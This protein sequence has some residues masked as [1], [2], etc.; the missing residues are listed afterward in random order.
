MYTIDHL[1]AVSVVSAGIVFA[2]WAASS[3]LC[4]VDGCIGCMRYHEGR[5]EVVAAQHAYEAGRCDA[6]D[7]YRR[8]P[9][10]AEPAGV[11]EEAERVAA[12]AWRA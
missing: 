5:A 6:C 8:V 1:I 2:L 3:L 4:R 7:L 12:A 10:L 11:V 9:E